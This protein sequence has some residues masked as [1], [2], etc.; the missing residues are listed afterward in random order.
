MS[1]KVPASV[2]IEHGELH[3]PLGTLTRA[4]G[5]VGEAAREVAAL[6]KL[7]EGGKTEKRAEA[8]RFAG[9]PRVHPQRRSGGFI[10]VDRVS[11]EGPRGESLGVLGP[12]GAEGSTT[13]RVVPRSW[14]SRR[15]RGRRY[16]RRWPQSGGPDADT[17]R[18]P[19]GRA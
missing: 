12:I 5:R 16:G 10:A 19:A 18:Q 17:E 2:R 14:P 9:K 8:E 11:F 3:V 4:P 7:A 6:E 15:V 1:I 13:I